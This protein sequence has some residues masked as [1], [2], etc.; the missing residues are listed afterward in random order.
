LDRITKNN[1]NNRLY[2]PALPLSCYRFHYGG[3]PVATLKEIMPNLKLGRRTLASLPPVVKTTVF[4]DADLTG[5][6]LKVT[7]RALGHGL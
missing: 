5:F 7:H 1:K 6:G 3:D 4:Y 2:F